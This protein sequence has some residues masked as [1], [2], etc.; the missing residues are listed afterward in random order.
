MSQRN[1]YELLFNTVLIVDS[2]SLF[3]TSTLSRCS[4]GLT[5]C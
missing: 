1:S 5:V 4:K 3:Y 2:L